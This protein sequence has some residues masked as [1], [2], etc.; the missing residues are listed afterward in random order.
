M[1]AYFSCILARQNP[2]ANIVG[3]EIANQC[4]NAERAIT[5]QQLSNVRV[6][7]SSFQKSAL[8]RLLRLSIVNPYQLPRSVA[9]KTAATAT[10]AAW[11]KH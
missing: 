8:H 3:L 7:Q 11:I 5:R 9:P 4:L 2:D 1:A 10:Y 6:I